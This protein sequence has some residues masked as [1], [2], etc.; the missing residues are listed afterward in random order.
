[1]VEKI[2][3]FPSQ[4]FRSRKIWKPRMW[5]QEHSSWTVLSWT[6]LVPRLE[7]WKKFNLP[8][9]HLA[10]SSIW[11]SSTKKQPFQWDAEPCSGKWAWNMRDMWKKVCLLFSK[12]LNENYACTINWFVT[13]I[14][15]G[16]PWKIV[17]SEIEEGYV[18]EIDAGIV[19]GPVKILREVDI[20][21][22]EIMCSWIWV[23]EFFS[24]GKTTRLQ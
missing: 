23:V 13:S 20:K 9:A 2:Y 17:S 16:L 5:R 1:M 21:V 4:R 19:D 22:T 8:V 10:C 6:K 15:W 18:A 12:K 7:A 3:R 14:I 11:C 24:N